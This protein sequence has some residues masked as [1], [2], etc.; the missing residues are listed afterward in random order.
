MV[1][2][3]VFA[4]HFWPVVKH[5]WKIDYV[6]K[7]SRFLSRRANLEDLRF[8]IKDGK[9][10]ESNSAKYPLTRFMTHKLRPVKGYVRYPCSEIDAA[11]VKPQSATSEMQVMHRV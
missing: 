7:L 10:Y 9:N 6:V 3:N 4:G 11:T 8:Q 1:T 2:L 5:L